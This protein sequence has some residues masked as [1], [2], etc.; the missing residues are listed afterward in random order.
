MILNAQSSVGF[1]GWE[2]IYIRFVGIEYVDF[3]ILLTGMT[4]L[5]KFGQ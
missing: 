3:E 2:N 5:L 4:R 1:N